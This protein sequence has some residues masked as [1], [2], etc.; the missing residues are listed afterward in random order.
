MD[1]DACVYGNSN[2]RRVCNMV[3][4]HVS[5]FEFGVFSSS[6][7]TE[8]LVR[9]P[10]TGLPGGWGGLELSCVLV[11]LVHGVS[12]YVQQSGQTKTYCA[13]ALLPFFAGISRTLTSPHP[14]TAHSQMI[15]DSPL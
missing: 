1:R 2:D 8:A 6:V 12:M 9:G 7:D 10:G 11:L 3:I 14:P 15:S 13:F 5:A 4:V